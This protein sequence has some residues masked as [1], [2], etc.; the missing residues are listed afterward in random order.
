[1]KPEKIQVRVK[2][3]GEKGN[4]TL[5]SPANSKVMDFLPSKI[6]YKIE[7]KLPQFSRYLSDMEKV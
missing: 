3:L 5:L 4:G 7:T 6:T 1:M 2:F